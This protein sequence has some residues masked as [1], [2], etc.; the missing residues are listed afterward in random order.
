M[1]SE[2][3]FMQQEDVIAAGILDMGKVLEMV[4]KA[5]YLEGQG[6]I[7]NPPKTVFGIPFGP[8]PQSHFF[9]M[10]VY[11]GGDV[12]RPGTKWAAES[13][14][15]TKT[16]DLPMG[17]DLVILSDPVT[18]QPV[19]IMDGMVITALGE[20]D[21]AYYEVVDI[22]NSYRH[23]NTEQ[24]IESKEYIPLNFFAYNDPG[25]PS[26]TAYTVNS[27]N[28]LP[29]QVAFAHWNNLAATAF[30]FVPDTSMTFTNKHNLLYQTAD[31]AYA[32]YYDMGSVSAAGAGKQ[33]VT[34]YGVYSNFTVSHSDNIAV[35]ITAPLSLSLSPDRKEYE[36]A[37]ASLPGKANF[38][39][40]A[41]FEN[42]YSDSAKEYAK[43][44][45]AFYTSNGI[46][47][48]DGAGNELITAPSYQEPYTVDFMN[49]AAG[50]TRTSTF[51]F[52]ADVGNSA[53]YRKV[54]MHVFDTSKATVGTESNLVQ[55][56][57]IG[58]TTFYILCPGGDG[59]LPKI[60]FTG[61]EP[62]ILYNEGT[63][64]L[65][66]TGNNIG[67]LNGDKS[68]YSLY[69]YNNANSDIRYRIDT[70]NILFPDEN[71]MD[72][73][74]TDTMA[75]GVYDLKFELTP[76][77]AETLACNRVLTAPALTVTMSNDL[78]YQNNYY[79]IVAVVQEGKQ[80]NAKYL[81]KS[82]KNEQ[83]F[84][85]DKSKYTEV[86]LAFRGEFVKTEEEKEVDKKYVATSIKSTDSNG[87]SIVSNLISINN[88]MILKAVPFLS[89]ISRKTGKQNQSM[90]T[91]TEV[92][93]LQMR[94][95]AYGRGKQPLQNLK[96][97]KNIAWFHIMTAVKKCQGSMTM[98][99]HSFGQTLWGLVK[100]WRV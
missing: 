57:L 50:Q 34:N 27:A 97:G 21:F 83:E 19:A 32:L 47:P 2:L 56:N 77:F 80:G 87:N 71:V 93:I 20:Q 3:L 42:Y 68:Q 43:A 6:E 23:I 67:M 82:Y 95:Q 11:I 8:N 28:A 72:V 18:V 76:A 66:I 64:H 16:G 38:G 92:F 75:P 14:A 65:L 73:I 63:R 9:S 49:F 81:I 40:Q 62:E 37:D 88:C 36:K 31:S 41:Q 55:E 35:N 74:F 86:L 100:H 90:L 39:V 84:N 53:S 94:E 13:M 91:L 7:I 70:Q 61:R 85:K 89:I 44:T 99:L 78:Q 59:N 22:N 96:T 33:V 30:D 25:A 79:G 54:E 12:N 10:P 17:I 52:K 1:K 69:A 45:V 5:F 29:Y 4:E 26:I 58:S 46:T 60:T 48:L 24:V 51:Y 15:N 98:P